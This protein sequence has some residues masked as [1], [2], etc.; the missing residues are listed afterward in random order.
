[1]CTPTQIAKNLS[2]THDEIMNVYIRYTGDGN[3]LN[4]T[5]L[6]LKLHKWKCNDVGGNIVRRE[7]LNWY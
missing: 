6:E 4:I 2:F 5:N 1:M 7:I 3:R